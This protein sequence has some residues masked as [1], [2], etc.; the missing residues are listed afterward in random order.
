[1]KKATSGALV[2]TLL[3]SVLSP[4]QSAFATVVDGDG[5]N[6][7][8][9]L[10]GGFIN[11]ANSGAY[12]VNLSVSGSFDDSDIVTVSFDGGTTVTITGSALS[13]ATS[14]VLSGIDLSTL[15]EGAIIAS[16]SVTDSG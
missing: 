4:W 8:V 15:A 11:L 5:A 9:G 3:F 13:G 1:M 10:N 2:F 12:S 14:L 6:N 7:I 16:G